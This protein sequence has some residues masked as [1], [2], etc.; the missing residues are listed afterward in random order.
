MAS[1]GSRSYGAVR[2][3]GVDR[4]MLHRYAYVDDSVEQVG[5][6]RGRPDLRNVHSTA[7]ISEDLHAMAWSDKAFYFV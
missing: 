2:M 1:R 6:S 7:R 4:G 3:N 5:S